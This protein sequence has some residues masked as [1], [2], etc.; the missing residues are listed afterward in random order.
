[1]ASQGLG[2]LHADAA[3]DDEV[4]VRQPAGV[5]GQLACRGVLGYPCYLQG[6]IQGAGGMS[7]NKKQGMA[8]QLPA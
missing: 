5:Q 2:F 8:G 6:L 3:L 7:R 1:M 4:V